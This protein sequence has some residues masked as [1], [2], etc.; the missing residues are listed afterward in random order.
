[1]S[2]ETTNIRTIDCSGLSDPKPEPKPAPPRTTKPMSEETKAR[3]RE[4][5]ERRKGRV[6]KNLDPT[7]VLIACDAAE[8]RAP[9]VR[10]MSPQEFEWWMLECVSKFSEKHR[11]CWGK[12]NYMRGEKKDT[13]V[14]AWARFTNIGKAMGSARGAAG[15]CAS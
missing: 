7:D 15:S 14:L 6:F 8:E 1:M 9:S 10:P 13:A 4:A 5:N 12:W 11:A 3:L 2:D